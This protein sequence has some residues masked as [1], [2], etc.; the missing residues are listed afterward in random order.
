MPRARNTD[1][2]LRLRKTRYGKDGRLVQRSHWFIYDEGRQV[3]HVPEW[4]VDLRGLGEGDAEAAEEQR[5]LYTQRKYAEGLNRPKRQ[6]DATPPEETPV[7]DVISYY[8][9]KTVVRYDPTEVSPRG[10]PRQ[11]RD[12]LFRMGALLDYWGDKVVDDIDMETCAAFAEHVRVDPGRPETPGKSLSRSVVRRCLE[13]LRAGC[14]LYV[15]AR[16]MTAGGDYAFDLPATA[17]ARFGFYT[18]SQMA[19]LV[20]NAYRMKR[21]YSFTG[22]RA[23]AE[24]RGKVIETTA[25]PRRHVARFLLTGV[26]TG[27]RTDRIE[28][29]SFY[30]EPG[31]PWIDVDAGVFYRAWDGEFVPGNKG[32][33]PIRIPLRLL[34]HMRRWKRNGAR[35]LIEYQ[36]GRTGSTANAFFANLREVLS[37][38]EIEAMDLNRHALKHTCATW[39]MMAGEPVGEIA[40]YLS[41]SERIVLKHYGHHHPDHQQAIGSAFSSGRAGR[42]RFGREA[43]P[44]PPSPSSH[45]AVA[46]ETRRSVRELLEAFESPVLAFTVLSA[47]PDEG[48]EALREQVKRCWRAGDW[49]AVL[50][51]PAAGDIG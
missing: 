23:K 45:P 48:L 46:A 35:Y 41:T 15:K 16:K 36:D 17:P 6:R 12:F 5:R 37:R 44:A 26:Y 7:A 9:Q 42:V 24:N 20:W 38:D 4:N 43:R 32:A 50:A 28:R 2:R 11:R 21:S 29:A 51:R 30:P 49:S 33:D 19:R 22:K 27:T 8:S 3:F 1:P 40:G 10:K 25:R 13:D 14:R 18:R 47:T 31:R 34:A 39:L